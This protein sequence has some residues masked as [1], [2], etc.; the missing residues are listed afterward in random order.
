MQPRDIYGRYIYGSRLL[1]DN[2]PRFLNGEQVGRGGGRKRKR[3]VTVNVLTRRPPGDLKE[4]LATQRLERERER[5]RVIRC[6][7]I[8]GH[9]VV[10]VHTDS[11][12]GKMRSPGMYNLQGFTSSRISQ[13]SRSVHERILITANR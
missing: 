13:L 8:C 10:I 3:R 1:S 6:E 11:R 12:C 4:S 9:S 5:E 7:V 2:F